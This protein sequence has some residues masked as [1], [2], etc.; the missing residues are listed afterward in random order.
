MIALTSPKWSKL[1]HAYGSAGDLPALLIQLK[2]LP[3]SKGW[4]TE[5]YYSLWSSLCHQGDAYEA[6]FAA[7]PHIVTLC[8][9]A[10]AKA[11]WELPQLCVYI[12]IARLEG[13]SPPLH[14]DLEKPYMEAIGKLPNLVAQMNTAN[15]SEFLVTVGA[16]AFAVS[17]GLYLLAKAYGEMTPEVAPKF[18]DWFTDL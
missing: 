6:S 14:A 4:K 7:V 2:A 9:S 10:V 18:L 8:E 5:P 1:S 11:P 16:A 13:R 3:E 12:E 15:P 17:N